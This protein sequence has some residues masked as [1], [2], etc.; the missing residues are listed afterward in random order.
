LKETAK[1]RGD[2]ILY[3]DKTYVMKSAAGYGTTDRIPDEWKFSKDRVE[4]L[5]NEIA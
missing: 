3:E 2:T 1:G 5:M 4:S